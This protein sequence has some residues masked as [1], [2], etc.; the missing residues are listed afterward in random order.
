[1]INTLLP[2][3]LSV[4]LLVSA[5]GGSS[6]VSVQ[7]ED[8]PTE[9]QGS[10]DNGAPVDDS[11]HGGE[12]DAGD[13]GE[14]DAG[15]PAPPAPD[16]DSPD[17]NQPELPADDETPQVLPPSP[18]NLRASRYSDTAA[19]LFWDKPEGVSG[20]ALRYVI[21][22]NGN[23]LGRVSSMSFFT[24][25]LQAG[26]EHSMSVAT[27][28]QNG[29]ASIPASIRINAEI[30]VPPPVYDFELSLEHSRVTLDEGNDSG[31]RVSINVAPQGSEAVSLVVQ[32][33]SPADAADIVLELNRDNLQG[34]ELRAELSL[35]LPVGMRPIKSQER[36]F[37]ITASSG[38]EVR[39]AELI[40]D[41][42]PVAAPDVYLLIGQSNMVGSSQT[43]AKDVSP[44]GLDERNGRIWQLNVAPNNTQIFSGLADFQSES[45]TLIE[46]HFIEAEDPLHDPR[47]PVVSFKGGTTIGPGL[48]FAKAAL[49]DT[50]QQIYLV[51]AAWGASGFCRVAGNELAWNAAATDNASLGGIG[52]LER[53]LT[54]L[55]ITLRETGGVLRGILWH[56][57]GA[58][59][60]DQ[61]CA[62]AYA[63]NLKLMV[64]RIRREAPQD[65]RGEAARGSQ[66]PIPFIVATQ[67]RGKDERG[68]YSL[69]ASTK[70]Q[71]DGVHRNIASLLPY[72]DWVNNDDLVPPAYPCGSS[73]CVHFGA[74]ASRETGRRYYE[75]LQR[76][77]QR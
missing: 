69:W 49:S 4:L 67:S 73:S 61:A 12:G 10:G 57:G 48:S 37:N 66:A 28:D 50:T 74:T 7:P 35:R 52:L 72:A 43:G 17:V 15:D 27:L 16:V 22:L 46:P 77:W 60:N 39:T 40:V 30:D 23:E 33:Q 64:E 2:V 65:I 71:V 53:A 32:G 45:S 44:G 59:S 24:E 51:P 14:D 58:D 8:D 42:K 19:E 75:A 56:Q 11:G 70:S 76:I 21:S 6:G 3:L 13:Q 41:V 18:Q 47:N 34:D 29:L 31:S 54:R 38:D 9:Q 25:S 68:D 20:D 55:R 62:D 63:E 1:M 36:R 5:C 26:R